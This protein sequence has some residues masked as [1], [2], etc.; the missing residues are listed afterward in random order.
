MYKEVQLNSSNLCTGIISISDL[1]S[2]K[3][4][5]IE[6]L[7]HDLKTPI[8]AQIRALEL[9]LKGNFGM[10]NNEQSEIVQ[11]TLESCNH[12]Y[13]MVSTLI[14]N[15]KFDNEELKLHYSYFD[16]ISLIE[17][18]IKKMEQELLSSNIKIVIIPKVTNSFITADFIRI[19]KVVQTLLFNSVNS[20]F[21]NSIIKVYVS[22]RN[23]MLS[24]KI[25][26]HS[27]HISQD[28]IR[29]LFA[30]HTY[31]SNKFHKIG[32]GIGLY[33]VKK[34]VEKHDGQIIAESFIDQRNIL[35]FKIPYSDEIIY[36]NC[37]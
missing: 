21:K 24:V 26:N 35:G 5:F 17:E 18:N 14:S 13:E 36:K 9:M 32:T 20:A 23:K 29:Q 7:N 16:I 19:E 4:G 37:I 30:T 12:M 33:F 31:H 22:D 8:I 6:I 3:K 27:C 2:L 1:Q 11:L 28:K 25:E 10:L 34:I 15:Y